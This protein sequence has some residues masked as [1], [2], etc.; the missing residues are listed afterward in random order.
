M[1]CH[2]YTTDFPKHKKGSHL[3]Q[4]ER[5]AIR[6]L[7]ALKY[8]VRSVARMLGCSPNTVRNELKRGTPPQKR[9][10]DYSER[11]GE[12]VYKANRAACHRRRKSAGSFSR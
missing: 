10:P 11:R 3:T 9:K 4:E 12:A 7:N 5:M 1:D 6:V 8:S 2:E